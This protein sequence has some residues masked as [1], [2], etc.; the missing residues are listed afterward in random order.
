M[1]WSVGDN[2]LW[3]DHNPGNKWPANVRRAPD[4]AAYIAAYVSMG[5]STGASDQ[6]RQ[7]FEKIALYAE[8]GLWKHV[9]RQLPDGS[10]TSKLGKLEDIRHDRLDALEALY[11]PVVE[12]LERPTPKDS[13]AA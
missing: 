9:A 11:G 3:W 1:A 13:A 10:W 12:I 6:L 4:V 2:A 5:Y 7:G 8:A